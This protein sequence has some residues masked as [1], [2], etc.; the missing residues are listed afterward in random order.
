M[1]TKH[2]LVRLIVCLG[3]MASLTPPVAAAPPRAPSATCTVDDD[4]AA[5]YTTIQDAVDDATCSTITVAAGS[6]EEN[7]VIARSLTLTGAGPAETWVGG[8]G[9]VFLI[10]SSSAV[11]AISGVTIQGVYHSDDGTGVYNKGKLTLDNVLIT[12][13]EAG[14]EGGGICNTGVLTLTNSIVEGGWADNGGGIY[15]TYGGT[16]TIVDSIIRENTSYGNGGGVFS[17]G[18]VVVENSQ[19]V[20]NTATGSGGGLYGDKIFTVADSEIAGNAADVNGGG[21]Y[22][23]AAATLTNAIVSDNQTGQDGGGIYSENRL[24]IENSYIHDNTALHSDGGG[25]YTY[26]DLQITGSTVSGNASKSSGGGIWAYAAVTLTNVTISGNR[27]EESGGGVYVSGYSTSTLDSVTI[28]DNTADSDGD[29]AGDG[30]GLNGPAYGVM[31][32]KNTLIAENH[33]D[34]PTDVAPDC[35][36]YGSFTTLGYNL[37]GDNT[38]CTGFVSVYDQVGTSSS[39]LNPRLS[40]LGDYGGPTPVHALLYGRLIK[41]PAV[42]AGAPTCPTTD[43]RG[44]VRPLD[45]DEDGTATCDIGAYELAPDGLIDVTLVKTV[46]P[47]FALPGNALTYTLTF[48]NEGVLAATGVRITDTIPASVTVVSVGSDVAINQVVGTQFVW[49]VQDLEPG[50]AGVITISGVL[51]DDLAGGVFTNTATI[52]ADQD[53]DPNND[54][55]SVSV[56]VVPCFATPDDGATVYQSADA[57]ALRDAVSAAGAGGVVKVAGVCAGSVSGK[58]VFINKDLTLRGGYADGDWNVADPDNPATLDAQNYGS[59]VYIDNSTVTLEYLDLTGGN[60]SSK[61]GAVYASSSDVTLNQVNIYG[62]IADDYGGGVYANVSTVTASATQILSNTAYYGGGV[63]LTDSNAV[64]SETAIDGN[65]AVYGGGLWIDESSAAISAGEIANNMVSSEGGGVYLVDGSITLSATHVL[66]NT[67]SYKGGGIY[68]QSGSATVTDAEISGNTADND[69]G[70][71]LVS[72][73]DGDHSDATLIRVMLSNNTAGANGGGVYVG[74]G[75]ITLTETSIV[76][77]TTGDYGG[78]VYIGDGDAAIRT[79]MI[80]SNVAGQRGGGVYLE[81]GDMTL[82]KTR[83]TGNTA[84]YGGGMYIDVGD[85][86][87]NAVDVAYNAVDT[88]GGGIYVSGGSTTAEDIEIAY[89]TA[90]GSGGGLYAADGYVDIGAARIFSN[91]AD[92]NGGGMYIGAGSATIEGTGISYNTSADYGGGVY[93]GEGA[94][95]LTGTVIFS[96]TSRIG[97]GICLDDGLMILSEVDIINNTTSSYAG[98]IHVYRGNAT[99]R[100]TQILSNTS[101]LGGGG[102]QIHAGSATLERVVIAANTALYGGGVYNRGGVL[103]LTNVTIGQNETDGG[104]G[105]GIDNGSGA[106]SVLTFTTIA[107]NVANDEG[108][109]IYSASGATVTLHN[110]LLAGNSPSNC[111]S[112]VVSNGYNLEDGDTCGFTATG[113]QQNT[114]PLLGPLSKSGDTLVYAL[115]PG[116]PAIDAGLCVPGIDVDQRGAPRPFNTACDVGAYESNVPI[117]PD[118]AIAKAVTPS[119][120]APGDVIT[121]TLTFTNVSSVAASGVIITD[122]LPLGQI[123]DL[124]YTSSITVTRLPGTWYVWRVQNLGAGMSGVITVRGTLRTPLAAGVFTNT[125]E[126]TAR[127]DGNAGNNNSSVQATVLNVAPTADDA[128]LPP[129]NEEASRNAPFPASDRNGDALTYAILTAPLSGTATLFGVGR[130]IYTPTNQTVSY[131]DTL[132]YIVTDTG[133]LSDTGVVAIPVTAN[134]DPPT[135]SDIPN[136]R[137]DPGV[138]VGPIA[139]TVG[140][141]DTPV[142]TLTLG[143]ASSDTT[144][145]PLANIAFGGSGANRTVVV[146]PTAGMTGTALITVTVSDGHSSRDNAFALAVG[147]GVNSPPEF[148]SA[149]VTEATED[150]MYTYTVVATDLDAG[151][152]LTIVAALKPAWLTLTQPTT[153]TAILSGLPL[154]AD[155]GDHNVRLRVT[156]EAGTGEVQAFVITVANVNDAP[157]ARNDF[158]N[159]NELTP[160]VIPVLGNDNDPDG[161]PFSLTAV[162]LPLYGSA[163]IS[164]GVVV[165]TPTNRTASYTDT[166]TYTISDGALTDTANVTVAVAAINDPPTISDIADRQTRQGVA[167]AP[168]AFTVNDADTPLDTL[169]LHKATSN[170]A[171]TPLNAIAFGGS[172]A[173]RTVVITPTAALSGAAFITVTVGD[174][175]AAAADSFLLTVIPNTAPVFDT[176]PITTAFEDIDYTYA[177]RAVD[178]DGDALSIAAPVR[179]LWLRLVDYGDGHAVL[180]G[181]PLA[182][183]VGDHPVTLRAVDSFGAAAIQTF[184]VTVAAVN[185]PPVARDDTAAT[186]ERTPRGIPVLAND[187]DP[188]SALF[189]A[190]VSSPLYGSAV[191]SGDVVIYTPANRTAAYTDTFDYVAS[192]G[193]LEDTATV[194]VAVAAMDDPPFISNVRNQ[195]ADDGVPLT[196]PFFVNDPDTPLDLLTLDKASSDES[197]VPLTN[198][199]FGGSGITRTVTLTPTAG[200]SGTASIT[201]TVGDGTSTAEDGFVLAVDANSPPEF[202]STPP[203]DALEGR[204][205]VYRIIA[206]DVETNTLTITAPISPTW[207]TLYDYHNGRATLVG[208]PLQEDIGEHG[209][210]LRVEDNEGSSATQTF[211]ITVQDALHPPHAADDM[212][213]TD[214]DTPVAIPVLNNDDDL[215]GDPLTLV[216][217]TQPA[218]GT[219]GCDTLLATCAYTPVNSL[220][221]YTATFT[222]I[223]SDGTF[224]DTAAVMV[225]VSAD[226]DPPEFTNAPKITATVG[227]PYT[228]TVIADDADSSGVLTIT[229]STLPTWLSLTQDFSR[230]ATLAGTPLAVGE[231]PV[232]LHVTDGDNRVTQTFTITVTTLPVNRTPVADAGPDQTVSVGAVVTLDGS[233]SYDPEGDAL[234]YLWRQTGGAPVTFTANVSVTTFTAPASAGALT[235]TLTVTDTGGL[236]GA[237]EVVITV[238]AQPVNHAPTANAGDDQTVQTGAVVTL[239]GSGSFDPDGDALAY[240][241]RQTGGAPV[242]FT[243]NVSVTTF[244][245]PASAGALT[246]TLTVTDTGGLTGTDEVVITVQ[247]EPVNHAPTANAGDDQTVQAGAVVTLDGSGSSDPDGDALAYLWRQTGGA[248]V[249][250]TADVSV[251]TFTAPSSTDV[252]TFTLTVTDTGGLVDTD[253]VVIKINAGE[254]FIFLPLVLRN[255]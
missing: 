60:A 10:D 237:D 45:G 226:N 131:T 186:D 146:T 238:Q 165:Y 115:Q 141:V 242:T 149:P 172:G 202:V 74:S 134:D 32:V 114:D 92:S 113:D 169:T 137:T 217:W 147:A 157:I 31:L 25:I 185:D 213:A 178:G 201:L 230:T 109:G 144:L 177:I 81:V 168:I 173:A 68:I 93:V 111:D 7:V 110:T 59:V 33:D 124:S 105:G 49:E 97:G 221:A 82:V 42:D 164:S 100:E 170:P 251:T 112:G 90:G 53:E 41:S 180:S 252:L 192:D 39:P 136:Q 84:D 28:T 70:G 29:N 122:T 51:S 106:T 233:G 181:R 85:A 152:A 239:D 210:T 118:V 250:F 253:D 86:A 117:P 126:I 243:A 246:F 227:I 151:D 199:T 22:A 95:V 176:A 12:D 162:G 23:S 127:R 83:F 129:V 203:T 46:T 21:I 248:P 130:F 2:W 209:V 96:N 207:L 61:G 218:F 197:L 215:D 50:A 219:A 71:I 206:V 24:L 9:Q 179:P 57:Q 87:L 52:A 145:V 155:V 19:V 3:L 43:Q 27:T 154:N 132:T 101:G 78:G 153:R 1:N 18:T 255:N 236:T 190:H 182:G 91:T 241:W 116:S 167:T 58:V 166:F 77:N 103:A 140:D 11:V 16:L 214:E 99:L 108:G 102:I 63:Y 69:G 196:V 139:F 67:S 119:S 66:S 189:I 73:Y 205:Y 62:N 56:T 8:V 6:Y 125:A 142:D 76:S 128:T 235:F 247:A 98:G 44:A 34:S 133:G 225:A 184:T 148:V 171:L 254:C 123:G 200:L 40:A 245:A 121:Y 160:R 35:F 36:T 159:T 161:D 222:Y 191:I 208:K 198:I 204:F 30:G 194:V 88:Y 244:T 47:E 220:S 20:S 107:G 80:D 17:Y 120:A 94:A 89:N 249:T 54:S 216:A 104:D 228:H 211:T 55:S 26:E 158:A 72:T 188:D 38:G 15:N 138:P 231:Y 37:I 79:T 13:N 187:S 4:G 163:V 223:I 64:M 135:I 5:D 156:D 150:A 229:A 234:A 183:D 143:A 174:G 212:V 75:S 240:L 232:A 65:T 48:T 224:T 195:A 193:E 14:D 175:H